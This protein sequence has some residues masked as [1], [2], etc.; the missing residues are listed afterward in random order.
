[1]VVR[2]VGGRSR[3]KRRKRK[4]VKRSKKNRK[5]K[6]KTKKLKTEKKNITRKDK[7]APKKPGETLEFTC[8]TKASLRHM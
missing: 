1:M 3:R 5:R 6:I 2:Y 8:Y 4:R 7:C